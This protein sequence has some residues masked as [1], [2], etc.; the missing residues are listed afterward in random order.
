[1]KMHGCRL[2]QIRVLE[3]FLAVIVVFGALLLSRPIY[4]SYDDSVDQEILYSIGMNVLMHLDQ[5]GDLGR[6]ISQRDWTEISS[7]LSILLPIGVSYNLT[8]YDEEL[9]I[10]NNSPI[11][12]GD[13]N[14]KGVVSIQYVVVDRESLNLYI[15]RLQLAW[16][17]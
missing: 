14:A 7:R 12:S 8:V 2:G 16:V 5:D 17:K 6:L 13:L 1:M 11:L 4:T 10:L 3:A 9:N 15:V